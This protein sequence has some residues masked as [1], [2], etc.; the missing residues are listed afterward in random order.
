MTDGYGLTPASVHAMLP[1]MKIW[2]LSD[3]HI[4]HA[5]WTPPAIPDA[6]V[7]VVAGDVK[8]GAIPAMEWLRHGLAPGMPIVFVLGNHEFYGSSLEREWHLARD[9]ARNSGI[10][11]LDDSDVIINGVRFVGGTLWSDFDI[12]SGG[13]DMVRQE[14]MAAC[15]RWINDFKMIGIRDFSSDRFTPAWARDLHHNTEAYI[16]ETLAVPHA[17]PTVVVTHHAPARGSIA[18][19]YAQSTLTPAF[20]S[21]LEQVI[22]RNRPALWIHGHV[23][24]TFDYHVG[25]ARIVCNPRGYGDENAPRFDPGFIV[26]V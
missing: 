20:V 23:H 25:S 19:D 2:L 3:L 13:D 26:E 8:Q 7:C 14:H 15:Q 22:H 12:F 24:D 11:L 16:D 5:A 21:D 4:D 1:V 17:G 18:S 9:Y 10:H 6:D